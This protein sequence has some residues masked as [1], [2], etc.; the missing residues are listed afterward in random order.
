M[1]A[2][3]ILVMD[4]G[5]VVQ[6]GT[7]AEL[8]SHVEG[9]RDLDNLAAGFGRSKIDRGGVALI[10][11]RQRCHRGD[12]VGRFGEARFRQFEVVR[13]AMAELAADHQAPAEVTYE[14]VM[15]LI[16]KIRADSATSSAP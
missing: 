14:R 1:N 5:E 9:L 15:E 11:V 4:K 6:M 16:K 13:G 7:H 3:L 8:V 2:D 12:A 10:V